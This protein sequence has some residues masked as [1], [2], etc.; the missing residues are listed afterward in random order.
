MVW[1][2][3]YMMEQQADLPEYVVTEADSRLDKVY[4]DHPHSNAGTHLLGG[5]DRDK[6]WQGRWLETMQLATT[7]YTVPKGRI[8][9][10]YCKYLTLLWQGVRHRKWNNEK[11]LPNCGWL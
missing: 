11:V 4:G 2:A 7:T 3:I 9:R 6:L 10:R 8:G 1:T 5:I